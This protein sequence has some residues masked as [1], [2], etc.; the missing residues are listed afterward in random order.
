MMFIVIYSID[1]LIVNSCLV[2]VLISF[3]SS[4]ISSEIDDSCT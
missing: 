3:I 4:Y 2:N 1:Y